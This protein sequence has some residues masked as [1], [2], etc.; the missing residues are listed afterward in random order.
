[1]LKQNNKA[2]KQLH[3]CKNIMHL[4][5]TQLYTATSQLLLATRFSCFPPYSY[6]NAGRQAEERKKLKSEKERKKI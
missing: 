4:D 1:M 6:S 2:N 5:L 3:I